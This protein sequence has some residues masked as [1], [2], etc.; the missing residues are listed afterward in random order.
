MILLPSRTRESITWEAWGP[1][2]T[3]SLYVVTTFFP[4]I[5]WT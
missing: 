4:S 1:S 3:L 2:G 5:F